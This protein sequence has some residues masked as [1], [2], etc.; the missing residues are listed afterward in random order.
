MVRKGVT[1]PEARELLLAGMTDRELRSDLAKMLVGLCVRNTKLENLHAGEFPT[2][3]T[4]DYS[5]VKAVGPVGEIPWT[6]LSRISDE[7]MKVLMIEVVNKV[8]TFLGDPALFMIVGRLL[9]SAG[10]WNLPEPDEELAAVAKQLR[11][12]HPRGTG[13]KTRPKD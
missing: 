2:S 6:R 10:Q 5:D 8:F 3:L 1:G 4:G 7:E 12:R 9:T 11:G 13:R